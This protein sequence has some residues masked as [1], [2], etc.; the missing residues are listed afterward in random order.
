MQRTPEQIENLKKWVEALRSGK[1]TQ[2]HGSLMYDGKY[3]CLGVYATIQQKLEIYD[4]EGSVFDSETG[5]YKR[6]YLSKE[7][8]D[9]IGF[10]HYDE[11]VLSNMNDFSDDDFE[12]IADF[13]EKEYIN[14]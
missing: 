13:I 12:E 10:R 11:T 3:C 7:L 8:R 1:Y 2:G 5:Q 6:C 4:K 14:T 9:S